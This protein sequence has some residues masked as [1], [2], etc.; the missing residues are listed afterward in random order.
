MGVIAR[1]QI[2]DSGGAQVGDGL[3]MAGIIIGAVLLV[4]AVIIIL[5]IV[6]VA[7]SNSR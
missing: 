4:L 5:L 1:H 2:R 3:A 7:G 6:G